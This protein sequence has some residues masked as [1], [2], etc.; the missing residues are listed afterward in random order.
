M[1]SCIGHVCMWKKGQDNTQTEKWFIHKLIYIQHEDIYTTLTES[2]KIYYFESNKII[3]TNSHYFE[4]IP[5]RNSLFISTCKN[6][7]LEL[8]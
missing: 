1:G 4:L 5:Y 2:G 3:V 7:E 6:D 8:Q